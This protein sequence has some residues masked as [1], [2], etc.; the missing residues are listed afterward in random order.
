MTTRLKA[1]RRT[2]LAG[3]AAAAAAPALSLVPAAAATP[4]QS[5]IARLWAQAEAIKAEMSVHAEE[6][7]AMDELTG[8]AGW[9]RL[10]GIANELGNRRYQALIAIIKATP[11]SLGD[12]TLIARATQESDIRRDG[13]AAWSHGEFDRAARE[14]HMSA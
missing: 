6:I 7:A 8:L 4:G 9:M 10:G 14:Y 5:P 1:T 13:P 11:A 12:L 2:V 3:T